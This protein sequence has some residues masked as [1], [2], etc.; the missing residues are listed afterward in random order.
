MMTSLAKSGD[1]LTDTLATSNL[2]WDE[3]TALMNE[4][5]KRYA[6]TESRLI[7]MQNA[8]NNVAVAVGDAYNPVLRELYK[9]G[10]D[11][12][13]FIAKFI[14][15]NPA[16]VNGISAAAVAFLALAGGITAVTVAVKAFLALKA[17]GA[18]MAFTNPIMAGIVAI[19]ALAGAVAF[20]TTA[21]ANHDKEVKSLT[22]SSR[23]QYYEL[24]NLNAEYETAVA[25]HG[26]ASSEAQNL[27]YEV[28]KLTQSYE[29]N[30]ETLEQF[31]A[32][33]DALIT[34]NAETIAGYKETSASLK[35]EELS[36]LA[37]VNQLDM[38]AANTGRSTSETE[39]LKSV[40]DDLNKSM[41]EL[42]LAYDE[43]TGSLN[44]SAGAVERMVKAEAAK[45][46][47]AEKYKA[48]INLVKK[49]EALK[50]QLAD[51][52][53]N[54]AK[55]R[56]ELSKTFNIKNPFIDLYTDL[57]DY[58]EQV[59]VLTASL[60]ENKDALAGIRTEAERYDKEQAAASS[61][62]GRIESITKEISKLKQSYDDAYEAAKQS[63]EGQYGLW[64]EA[65]KIIPTGVEK[66]IALAEGRSTYL[67]TYNAALEKLNKMVDENEELEGLSQMLK[68]NMTGS[69]ENVNAIIG[70]SMSTPE[71]LKKFADELEKTKALQD[72][73]AQLVGE[74]ETGYSQKK[75]LFQQA[76]EEALKA[77]EVSDAAS[78]SGADAIL[79]FI[80]GASGMTG[81]V[82]AAF[83]D[84][85]LTAASAMSGA[86][87]T[88]VKGQRNGANGRNPNG[89]HAGGLDYVPFDGYIAELH[90]G[91][92]VL[93]SKE[94]QLMNSAE[95]PRLVAVAPQLLAALGAH[96]NAVPSQTP[97]LTVQSD[98]YGGGVNI[99]FSPQYNLSGAQNSED[100][101]AVLAAHD[102]SLREMFV[103]VIENY[104][105]DN[106]RRK[107]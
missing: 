79:A 56:Q 30:K 83:R 10:T 61:A 58:Q 75:T 84:I 88:G 71:E 105:R 104:A 6:T 91:E 52:E 33:N 47:Q 73:S 35:D 48:W 107:Y 9:L 98:G 19:T 72:T 18:F 82:A 59:D 32:E 13:N 89:S 46:Q 37:L 69:A 27:R 106:A 25:Q 29:A 54:L 3:N 67:E 86:G 90:K 38:L 87:L 8:Y 45:Q 26:E 42:G 101:Q 55:R 20:L 70:M 100:L 97:P 99:T 66:M 57:D 7:M 77:K 36:A 62:Q 68:G 39:L 94:A 2:A 74:L 44:L 1:R 95:Q 80:A 41:P 12:L 15:Q 49:E 28:D 63:I 92:R 17:L 103:E 81:E 51:A 40:V 64:D 16:L 85:G 60:K 50:K 34:A 11:V 14:E 21:F 93:T 65:D 43:A 78:E 53:D 22:A 23:A 31:S 5:V 76:I 96:A 24:Q 102:E 4:A